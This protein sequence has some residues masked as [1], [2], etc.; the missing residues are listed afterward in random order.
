[1]DGTTLYTGPG[2]DINLL[3]GNVL[4]YPGNTSFAANY[5]ARGKLDKSEDE[6]IDD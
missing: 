1:M 6:D 2:N 3:V 5:V 4:L